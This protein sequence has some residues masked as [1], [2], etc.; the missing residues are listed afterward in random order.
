METASLLLVA[1]AVRTLYEIYIANGFRKQK[2]GFKGQTNP[3]TQ[4]P[5]AL[6]WFTYLPVT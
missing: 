2:R 1:D 3:V 6:N 4:E 5:E